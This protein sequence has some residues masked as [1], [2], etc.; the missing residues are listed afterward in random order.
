MCG[1]DNRELGIFGAWSIQERIRS[2]DDLA[3][4]AQLAK[5]DNL[6][7]AIGANAYHVKVAD[8]A[9]KVIDHMFKIADLAGPQQPGEYRHDP[10]GLGDPIQLR[11][12]RGT[13]L[14]GTGAFR[15]VGA[16]LA[17]GRHLQSR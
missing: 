14:H 1:E 12:E 10:N 15:A 5:I 2:L 8:L 16:A 13:V 6:R 7:K 9:D 3:D 4:E 11:P 17:T